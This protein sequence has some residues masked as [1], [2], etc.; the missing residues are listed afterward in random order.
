MPAICIDSLDNLNDFYGIRFFFNKVKVLEISL[1]DFVLHLKGDVKS[2]IILVG[3]IAQ[4][5]E[6]LVP[7]LKVKGSSLAGDRIVFLIIEK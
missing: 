2:Y 3:L 5:V 6:Q 7:T 4:L 1:Q